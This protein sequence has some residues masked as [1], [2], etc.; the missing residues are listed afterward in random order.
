MIPFV[1]AESAEHG[2][3]D[4]GEVRPP[5]YGRVH[6]C[7]GSPRGATSKGRSRSSPGST[8]TPR[9][10]RERTLLSQRGSSVLFGDFL[11]IPID[12]SFLYVQ[13][14]Y[15]QAQQTRD[16]A[17]Q[18]RD[19]RERQRRRGDDR[20]QPAGCDPRR[21]HRSGAV[22]WWERRRWRDGAAADPG[23]ARPGPAALLRSA[24]GAPVRRSGDLPDRDQGRAG[25]GGCGGEDL[26]GTTTAPSGTPTPSTPTPSASASASP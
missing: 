15:V 7:S 17:T 21:G 25:C 12:N 4:G 19:H 14:V 22:G 11:V 1:P 10:S 2:G 23:P 24:G 20:R 9:F 18:A 5:H 6:A 3:V 16:P 26:A 8:R 13:P